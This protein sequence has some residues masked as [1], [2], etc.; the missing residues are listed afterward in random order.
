MR[1]ALT[2]RCSP[3]PNTQSSGGD[4]P[5]LPPFSS[6]AQ[7]L[8]HGSVSFL[9]LS[10]LLLRRERTDADQTLLSCSFCP[11]PSPPCPVTSTPILILSGPHPLFH[12]QARGSPSSGLPDWCYL[13]AVPG[14]ACGGWAPW[15]LSPGVC[16]DRSSPV[17]PLMPR[18]RLL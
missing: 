6:G 8:F 12:P 18:I 3:W 10:S 4:A 14:R 11:P 5:L 17:P 13:G 9:R 1:L 2:S 16:A 7:G 15:E